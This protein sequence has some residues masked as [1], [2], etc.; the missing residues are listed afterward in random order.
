[1]Q[2]RIEKR[3]ALLRAQREQ[4]DAQLRRDWLVRVAPYDAAIVEL[5]SLLEGNEAND[6]TAAPEPEPTAE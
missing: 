4:I 2:E 5:E 3:L 1:M 6:V